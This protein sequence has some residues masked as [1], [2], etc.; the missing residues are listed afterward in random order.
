V[1][2]RVVAD[3]EDD[4][5]ALDELPSES[6]LGRRR[7]RRD[8]EQHEHPDG[9]RRQPSSH[10]SSPLSSSHSFCGVH[11]TQKPSPAA[12]GVSPPLVPALTRLPERAITY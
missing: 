11:S 1:I 10:S 8:R 6:R 5:V 4:D 2:D 3:V 7:L 9:S 12:G